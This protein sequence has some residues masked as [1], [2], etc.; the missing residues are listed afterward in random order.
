MGFVSANEIE[1]IAENE[2]VKIYPSVT[3]GTLHFISVLKVAS[4]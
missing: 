3:L 1:F 4:I 2:L